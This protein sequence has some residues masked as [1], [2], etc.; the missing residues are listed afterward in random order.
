MPEIR[1]S[2]T[3]MGAAVQPEPG[4]LFLDTG[5]NLCPGIIDHHQLSYKTCTTLLVLQRKELYT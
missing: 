3:T 1:L 5:N 2:F 4:K